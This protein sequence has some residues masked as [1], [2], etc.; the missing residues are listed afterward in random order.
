MH[1]ERSYF[2]EMESY[3]K[4]EVG[5]KSL[6]YGTAD[7][8]HMSGP[9]YPMVWSNSTLDF[10]GGH[11]Y[12]QHPSV[13]G[14]VNTPMVN[15][16]GFSSVMRLSRTALAGT[17]YVVPETNHPSPNFYDSEGIPIISAY[18]RFQDW[19]GI[20]MYTFELKRSR[21]YAPYI[22]DA[23]DI[24][25]HPVKM[26][27]MAAGALMFLR[28][29]VSAAAQPLERTYT[30]EQLRET[31]LGT[32]AERPYYTP[33]FDDLLVLKH[34]VRIGSMD[35]PPTQEERL[36]EKQNPIVSDTGELAWHLPESGKGGMVTIDTPR[37]QGIIGFVEEYEVSMENFS[38]EV[39]NEFCSITLSSLDEDTTAIAD[40]SRMLLVAGARAE[41]TGTIWGEA[42]MRITERGESPSLI[43]VV[44]GEVTLQGLEGAESVQ[45]HALDGSGQRMGKPIVPESA[46]SDRVFSI[47]DQATTWYEV[48]VER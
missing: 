41:N 27:Q 15:D 14:E 19:S 16:P 1:V 31:M 22:G 36:E 42:G 23:F 34:G 48:I 44:T 35:G 40:A 20:L 4:N 47:G 11:M 26:P 25:H 38:V 37:S 28:G 6:L 12:W 24:S 8:F 7:F 10:I 39:D 33:E 45:V 13:R 5:L 2:E 43:E 30:I 21:E 3:L 46:G 17:P 29:D 9:S 32:E 18:G